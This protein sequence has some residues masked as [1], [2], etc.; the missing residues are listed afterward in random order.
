MLEASKTAEGRPTG[1]VDR[2]GADLLDHLLV[3]RHCFRVFAAQ[4]VSI[5]DAGCD[6]GKRLTI[7]ARAKTCGEVRAKLAQ[8]AHA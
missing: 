4:R 2:I 8:K 1:L 6:T 7:Q 3:C 5:A